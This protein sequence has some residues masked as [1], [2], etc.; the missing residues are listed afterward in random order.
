M[1]NCSIFFSL[2]GNTNSL[3]LRVKLFSSDGLLLWTGGSHLSP[4]SDYLLLGVRNGFLEFRCQFHHHLMSSLHLSNNNL[5]FVI[6]IFWQNNTSARVACE[7][8][9]KLTT[10]STWETEKEFWSTITRKQ[11]TQNGIEFGQQGKCHWPKKSFLSLILTQFCFF[12]LTFTR[13]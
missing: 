13:Y 9:V 5:A 2:I 7:I 10:G 8:L 4:S 11:T 6:V 3:N 1:F 12:L